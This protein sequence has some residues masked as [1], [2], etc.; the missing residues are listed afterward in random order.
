MTDCHNN[1]A[2]IGCHYMQC[3]QLGNQ[4]LKICTPLTLFVVRNVFKKWLKRS[5][6]NPAYKA[7]QNTSFLTVPNSYHFLQF[8]FCEKH[9][10]KQ[11]T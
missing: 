3:S 5:V 2:N 9:P 11:I 6:K 4:V 1:A 8:F 7:N 10:E